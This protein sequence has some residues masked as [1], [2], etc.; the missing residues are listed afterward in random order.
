MD[1]PRD[2]TRHGEDHAPKHAAPEPHAGEH[3]EAPEKIDYNA[4]DNTFGGRLIQAGFITG[5]YA[6]GDITE[7]TAAARTALVA[8]NLATIAAF[9]AF[10]EDPANDLTATVHG[11]GSPAK[12]WAVISGLGATAAG[13]TAASS[14]LHRS[15]AQAL[16][17]R[18]ISRP[19]TLMGVVV[20][21]G[22]LAVEAA[23][24]GKTGTR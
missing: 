14:V 4:L 17:R 15:A 3:N 16:R 21:A 12:T 7:R 19:W 5:W 6:L 18:G 1:A 24:P 9:N 11:E 23:K 13:V 20:A 22:Y 10:D 8:A 2:N